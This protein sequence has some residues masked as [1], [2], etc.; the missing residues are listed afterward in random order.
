MHLYRLEGEV[1]IRI[2]VASTPVLKHR[3]FYGNRIVQVKSVM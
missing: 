2:L 3:S 1:M